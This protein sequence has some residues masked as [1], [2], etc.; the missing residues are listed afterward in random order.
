MD[1]QAFIQI[2]HLEKIAKD[3]GIDVPRLRGYRLM[4]NEIP[5]PI[6]TIREIMKNHEVN[7]CL[8]L[9]CSVPFWTSNS[10]CSECG[11][12]A[13]RLCNKYLISNGDEYV[14]IRWDKIHGRKRKILKFQ[15][16]KKHKRIQKQ[17]D[18][19]NKYAGKENILNI[20]ARIGGNNW[21]FFGGNELINK[22][23]FLDK[24]DDFFD[25]TYC[26]IYASI[27]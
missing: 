7:E 27:K 12:K 23:W 15:I 3:N 6:E 10:D 5:V 21:D 8:K 26:D 11:S 16:K 25:D 4:V 13:T 24:V 20:H 9:C 1:L 2:D 22:P 17:I 18:M 19:W 14:D